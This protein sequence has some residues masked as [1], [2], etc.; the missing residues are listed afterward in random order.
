MIDTCK[1]F[2]VEYFVELN[3]IESHFKF[4][5]IDYIYVILYYY[6]YYWFL[7]LYH[8]HKNW[9]Y[10]IHPSKKVLSFDYKDFDI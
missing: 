4:N 1:Y 8:C 6:F 2:Y 7:N 10:S 5:T 3:Q 9:S